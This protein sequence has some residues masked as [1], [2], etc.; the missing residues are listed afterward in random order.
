MADLKKLKHMRGVLKSTLT[1]ASTF[2]DSE[3]AHRI[4]LPQIRER[5]DKIAETWEQFNGIQT[6]IEE[7]EED[8]NASIEREEF[9]ES[10][11]D[12]ISRFN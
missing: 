12:I 6:K 2:L 7:I 10:Y 3:N 9:E 1:R 8:V 11:F 4:I 5:K